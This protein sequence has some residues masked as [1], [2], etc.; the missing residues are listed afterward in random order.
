MHWTSSKFHIVSKLNNSKVMCLTLYPAPAFS[1]GR[2]LYIR[3]S[4]NPLAGVILFT[5]NL[6]AMMMIFM[7]PPIGDVSHFIIIT[8]LDSFMAHISIVLITNAVHS[9]FFQ[10]CVFIHCT[11][12]HCWWHDTIELKF[13]NSL[14]C[15]ALCPF[16]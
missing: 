1:S 8:A 2:W 13:E 12:V 9:L 14:I 10:Q 4:K 15:P 7:C 5:T 6:V 11:I 3:W 16:R